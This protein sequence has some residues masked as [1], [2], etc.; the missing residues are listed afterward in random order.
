[1]TVPKK[2][3]RFS[4]SILNASRLRHA[5][6]L[7]CCLHIMAHILAHV[8]PKEPA[9]VLL[10]DRKTSLKF[11]QLFYFH[12]NILRSEPK[13]SFWFFPHYIILA[14]SPIS[15]KFLFSNFGQFTIISPKNSYPGTVYWYN[16]RSEKIYGETSR[17]CDQCCGSG[18]WIR[19]LGPF[20]PLPGS[21]FRELR[22]HFFVLKYL[23]SLIRIRNAKNSDPVSG[24]NIPNPQQWLR[25]NGTQT[26][27]WKTLI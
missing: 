11:P 5:E 22:N 19:D 1:M 18:S 15:S 23:N 27:Y 25:H 8:S 7:L 24:I 13:I 4:P 9:P 17:Y 12:Y 3:K 21:Y 6:D 14:S 2:V 16:W 26:K 20:G 10:D